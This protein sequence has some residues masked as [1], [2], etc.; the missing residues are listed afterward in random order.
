MTALPKNES[1]LLHIPPLLG[2]LMDQSSL[3]TASWVCPLE[4]R[5]QGLQGHL[6]VEKRLGLISKSLISH[7]NDF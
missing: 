2:S 3:C 4:R 5:R 7:K 1:V 6:G